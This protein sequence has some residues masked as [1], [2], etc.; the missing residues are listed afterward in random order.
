MNYF[1]LIAG[2]VSFIWFLV[3]FILGGKEVAAPLLSKNGLSEL[4]TAVLY[5]CWHLVSFLI[6]AKSAAYFYLSVFGE[7]NLALAIFNISFSF[8]FS[9]WGIYLPPKS[10]L[11]YKI[12]PQGWLFVPVFLLG[13]LGTLI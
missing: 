12:M 2:I 7:H 5:Y 3:H 11:S 10:D 4:Q 8:I 1:F 9:A 6:F 13:I